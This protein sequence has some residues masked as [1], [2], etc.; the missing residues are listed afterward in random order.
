L[1]ELVHVVAQFFKLII[2]IIDV[3]ILH[4]SQDP[5]NFVS[6]QI[7]PPRND[8]PVRLLAMST[9]QNRLS[10]FCVPTCSDKLGG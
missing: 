4:V 7:E 3:E 8:A 2:K 6:G 9:T 10:R 1:R 5:C